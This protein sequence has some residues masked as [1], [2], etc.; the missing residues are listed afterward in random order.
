[1]HEADGESAAADDNGAVGALPADIG[2]HDPA[3]LLALLRRRRGG[4]SEQEG[5][6]H[7]SGQPMVGMTKA[8]SP[9]A[10]PS[11]Q[12]W[13][14]F[15]FLVQKRTPSGPCWSMSPKPERFQPPNV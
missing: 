5:G 11:G 4:E 13:V 10:E 9:V 7:G 15:L 12:R 6:E 2:A 8:F 3:F 14:T 1:R